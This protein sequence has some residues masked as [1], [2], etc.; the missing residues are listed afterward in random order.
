MIDLGQGVL[1]E[2]AERAILVPATRFWMGEGLTI[3]GAHVG[4]SPQA[5]RLW[6]KR[7]REKM[8]AHRRMMRKANPGYGR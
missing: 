6:W 3:I 4:T 8:N 5:K 2:F 7:N 1:E